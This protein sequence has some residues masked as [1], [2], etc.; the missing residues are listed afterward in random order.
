[1][2]PTSARASPTT[3]TA[4][5]ASATTPYAST[6]SRLRSAPR[7]NSG[8]GGLGM[9]IVK[10][11]GNSR[12]G[13]LRRQCRRLDQRH[14][15]GRGRRRRPERLRLLL[16]ELRRRAPRLGLRHPGP[17][18]DHRPGRRGRLQ[19]HRLHLDLQRHLGGGADGRRRGVADVR[20]QRRA[21]AGA[22]C[23]PSS[24]ISARH[25]GS[26]VGGGIAGAERYAW[27]WNGA[28]TWNGGG[29]HFSNDYGYGL[30]DALAAVR[31][32]ET[33]LA[34]RHAGARPP[35]TSSAT[36]WT[37]ERDGGD[38]GRQCHRAHL[39]RKRSL[40]RRRRAGHASR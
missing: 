31:L 7:S 29:Q 28:D 34:D 12:G 22:T 15:P 35:P 14:P 39:H 33:W 8:R 6:R 11:A 30:V 3:S 16:F 18:G 9:T 26:A 1:M 37:A 2:S 21:S 36:P 40:R 13:R 27:G 10:S 25:V 23:S 20:R 5:S 32:A 19:R 24:P 38:P 4:S 17:G